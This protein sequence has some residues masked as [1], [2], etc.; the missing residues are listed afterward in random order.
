MQNTALNKLLSESESL[1]KIDNVMATVIQDISIKHL[2][3]LLSQRKNIE[4]IVIMSNDDN[5][6][7]L[8]LAKKA[9]KDEGDTKL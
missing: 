1:H 9:I 3:A 7:K 4:E 6:K 8:V 2:F 5:S